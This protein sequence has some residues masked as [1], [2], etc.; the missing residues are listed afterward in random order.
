MNEYLNPN[1]GEYIILCLDC[2]AKDTRTL[3]VYDKAPDGVC[4]ECNNDDGTP[5]ILT[6]PISERK[7]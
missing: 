3:Q 2:A 4:E 6:Y 7:K 5:P 1:T